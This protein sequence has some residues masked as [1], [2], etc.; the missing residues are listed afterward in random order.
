[1]YDDDQI[2]SAFD[3]FCSAVEDDIEKRFQKHFDKDPFGTVLRGLK[4]EHDGKV[5]IVAKG[6][7]Y[8]EEPTGL[9]AFS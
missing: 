3:D 9:H 5:T 7:D 2:E 6:P 1:M 8:T 4:D